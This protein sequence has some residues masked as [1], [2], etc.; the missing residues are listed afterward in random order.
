M[1]NTSLAHPTRT[2][3]VDHTHLEEISESEITG[4]EYRALSKAFAGEEKNLTLAMVKRFVAE[5]PEGTPEEWQEHMLRW[6]K[7]SGSG[8]YRPGYWDGYELSYE[9]NDYLRSIGRL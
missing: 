8:E 3:R 2:V 4:I 7:E 5:N 9:Y 1:D 6:A